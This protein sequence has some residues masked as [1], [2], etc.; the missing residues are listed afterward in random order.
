MK[1]EKLLCFVL[2]SFIIFSG[3]LSSQSCNSDQVMFSLFSERNSHVGS[4]SNSDYSVKACYNS[5]FGSEGNGERVCPEGS[6]PLFYKYA[7]ENSHVATSSEEATIPVCYGGLKC[8]AVEGECTGEEKLIASLSASENAHI[9]LGDDPE[10]PVKICCSSSSFVRAFSGEL[11]EDSAK[12]I[13]SKGEDI[14]STGNNTLVNLSFQGN[15]SKGA[16]LNYKIFLKDATCRSLFGIP[17]SCDDKIVSN[18]IYTIDSNDLL[19][20]EEYTGIKTFSSIQFRALWEES[21][22][23]NDAPHFFEISYGMRRLSQES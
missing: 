12:W 9:S 4:S 19:P 7:M 3:F 8:R 20:G 13:S 21:A 11:V 15:F 14:S 5:F 2:I 22:R 10:Y 18:G 17:L 6:S 16:V 23:R 1:R